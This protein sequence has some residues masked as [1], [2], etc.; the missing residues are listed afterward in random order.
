MNTHVQER[1]TFHLIQPQAKQQ[2]SYRSKCTVLTD[3]SPGKFVAARLCTKNAA[4]HKKPFHFQAHDFGSKDDPS[5]C[6]SRLSQRSLNIDW[7]EKCR[8]TSPCIQRL[9]ALRTDVLD[10]QKYQCRNIERCS[11]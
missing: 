6:Q 4:H 3:E 11:T 7:V 10:S 8:P 2:Q 1:I 9:D 5:P